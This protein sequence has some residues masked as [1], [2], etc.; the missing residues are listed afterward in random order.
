MAWNASVV[1]ADACRTIDSKLRTLSRALRSWRATCVGDIR[2]HLAVT[3]AVIY[4]LDLAQESRSLSVGELELHRDLKANSLGLASLERMMARQRARTRNLREGDACT[5]YFHLQA[6]HRQ[7]K[8]FLLAISHHGQTF[9]EDEAKAGI[10][11]EFYNNLLGVP[12]LRQHRLDLD[13]LGLPRLDLL[14]LVAPFSPEEVELTVRQ[15]PSDR[16]LGPDGFSGAFSKSAWSVVGP[17]VVRVFH[18]F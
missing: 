13:Q 3:R 17:D 11:F 4:E 1:D 16:A 6:Y 15:M 9:T 18:A 2:L 10:V 8:N 7:R 5:K 12:F 14:E